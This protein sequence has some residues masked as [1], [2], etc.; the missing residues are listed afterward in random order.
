MPPRPAHPKEMQL[1]LIEFIMS[2]ARCQTPHTHRL[3]FVFPTRK[4]TDSI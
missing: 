4:S 1:A 3:I 2:Q